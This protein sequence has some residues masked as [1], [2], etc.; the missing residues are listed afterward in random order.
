ML[1][2]LAGILDG[3]G[4][5]SIGKARWRKNGRE[6]RYCQVQLYVR[7]QNREPLDLFA[8][9]FGGTVKQNPHTYVLSWSNRKAGDVLRALLPY[10][11]VKK[12]Q[13][14]LALEFLSDPARRD[15]ETGLRYREKMKELNAH[16]ARVFYEMRANSGN[17]QHSCSWCASWR[18]TVAQ[19]KVNPEPSLVTERI[20]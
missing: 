15:W 13:A 1:E 20:A 7:M 8:Q 18:N 4:S 2:Y 19:E 5:I 9:R 17:G 11:R 16:D 12:P 6:Y 3:E 14:V 10:L